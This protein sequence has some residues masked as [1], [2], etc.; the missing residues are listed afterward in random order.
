M[1]IFSFEKLVIPRNED[2]EQF[3]RTLADRHRHA[4][5]PIFR[6]DG[7]RF[8]GIAEVHEASVGLVLYVQTLASQTSNFA[9]S[10]EDGTITIEPFFNSLIMRIKEKDKK[11][12]EIFDL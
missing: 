4:Q 1:D 5:Y 7:R 12:P 6:E 2:N 8:E 9:K 10:I 3:I 11:R